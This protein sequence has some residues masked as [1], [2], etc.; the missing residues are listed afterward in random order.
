MIEYNINDS[1][2]DIIIP[3]PLPLSSPS[4]Q[5]KRVR[6]FTRMPFKK[7]KLDVLKLSSSGI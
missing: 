7:D 1:S 5:P 6:M 3:Y 4:S 2:P